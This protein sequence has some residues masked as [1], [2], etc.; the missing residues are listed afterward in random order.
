MTK[1]EYLRAYYRENKAELKFNMR[2]YN[3]ANTGWL[4]TR[5]DRFKNKPCMDCRGWFDPWQMDFDHRPEEVKLFN[6]GAGRG[7]KLVRLVAEIKK[8][9]VVCSNC[10]RT[11]T[12]KRRLA[13]IA[14]GRV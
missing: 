7:L 13:A 3:A 4:R 2:L 8:C 14:K 6:I 12:H 9:D 10:H 5:L 1:T 11:R